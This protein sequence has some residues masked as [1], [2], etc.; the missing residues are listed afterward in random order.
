MILAYS[1]I[2]AL[3]L[4]TVYSAIVSFRQTTEE[5]TP[6]RILFPNGTRRSTRI[7]LC[8]ITIALL[9]GVVSWLSVSPRK[10]RPSSRFLIP[11]G[12]SGWV[13]VEFEIQGAPALEVENG[14]NV[15]RIPSSGRFKTSSPEKY[16]WAKD[17]FYFESSSGLRRIPDSGPDARI[18]GKINGEESGA[19]G[20]RKFEQFFVGSFQQFKDEA[21]AMADFQKAT[22]SPQQH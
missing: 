11:D 1:A 15:F 17:S 4:C 10:G 14:E 8:A 13:R 18:W 3:V 21:G 19:S 22:P 16:G 20:K 5:A 6:N 2:V 9:I 7:V 12:Y